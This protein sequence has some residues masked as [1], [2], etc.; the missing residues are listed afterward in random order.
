MA[1]ITVPSA[2]LITF[3]TPNKPVLHCLIC[4]YFKTPKPKLI[5][6]LKSYESNLN[7]SQNSN[8]KPIVIASIIEV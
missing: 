3:D 2:D 7:C 4:L 8:S 5:P 6:K 1:I